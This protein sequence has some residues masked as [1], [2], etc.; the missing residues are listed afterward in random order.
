MK[1]L[2]SLRS[3]TYA[4]VKHTTFIPYGGFAASMNS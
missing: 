3:L 2:L 1:Y 4:E